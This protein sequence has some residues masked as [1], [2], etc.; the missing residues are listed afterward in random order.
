M[1]SPVVTFGG[2]ASETTVGAYAL[3][4]LIAA[5]VGILALP[6]S[7]G[8]GALLLGAILIPQGNVIVVGGLH[9]QPA[10]VLSLVGMIRIGVG[11]VPR[12]GGGILRRLDRVVIAWAVCRALAISLVWMQAGA[13]I[14]QMGLLWS[15]LGMYLCIRFLIRSHS[16][17]AVA[18]K[19]LALAMAV[20][21][22]GGILEQTIQRNVFGTILGGV[23]EIP[24]VRNGRIR[25]QGPFGHAILGGSFAA[26]SVPLFVW[27]WCARARMMAAIGV[28][29]A[30]AFCLTT[31][32]STPILAYI[33]GVVTMC[34]WP[35]RKII[36][37]LLRC[38]VL[39]AVV[40]HVVMKA[41]VW[42]LIA[43]IDLTGGSS[44][45][46]RAKLIDMCIQHIGDWWLIGTRDAWSWG[47]DMW[48]LSNQY[49][50]ECEG[51]GI[52][53]FVLFIAAIRITIRSLAVARSHAP[54]GRRA[55]GLWALSA[56]VTAHLVAFFGASYW[57]QSQFAWFV[58]LAVSAIEA[59]G[60]LIETAGGEVRSRMEWWGD[61][62]GSSA[63]DEKVV[64]SA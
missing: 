54:V 31:A 63:A 58:L 52:V 25:S 15:V 26:T 17:A 50:A 51:G 23:Q 1:N 14:R 40:L 59:D 32:S 53:T 42:M 56:A 36:P 35:V 19:A 8:I 28:L 5:I 47:W 34:L 64:V 30:T 21:A 9:L 18:V 33:S 11:G 45:Y 62:I 39:L 13:V 48:D 49:V 44:G 10:K 60:D 4:A 57:D 22:V 20:V 27:L 46:H 3:V 16:D 37:L 12:V 38:L 7:Y 55:F 43:R 29:A 41:P 24:S 61:S 2:G 6:R